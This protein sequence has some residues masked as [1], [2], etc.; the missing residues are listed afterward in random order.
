MVAA[1]FTV[2]KYCTDC[3]DASNAVQRC[4]ALVICCVYYS[5][6]DQRN[7]YRHNCCIVVPDGSSGLCYN[8]HALTAMWTMFTTVQLQTQAASYILSHASIGITPC[9]IAEALLH[10][11]RLFGCCCCWYRD[12]VDGVCAHCC[13]NLGICY[14]L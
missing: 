8:V 14:Q 6:C 4:T 10:Q 13:T 12:S 5:A 9:N 1:W 2:M 11:P 7:Q 3:R